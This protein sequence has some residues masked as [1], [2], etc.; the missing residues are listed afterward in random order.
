MDRSS[1]VQVDGTVTA[2]LLHTLSGCS[3]RCGAF[4]T[5]QGVEDLHSEP[6]RQNTYL[7]MLILYN[8]KCF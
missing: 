8:L 1:V 6:Y 5:D 4:F 2:G 3:Q 7:K